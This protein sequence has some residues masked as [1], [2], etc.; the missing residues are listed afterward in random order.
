[1]ENNNYEHLSD[2][3]IIKELEIEIS[4]ARRAYLIREF[5]RDEL[6]M[7]YYGTI[8]DEQYRSS[9]TF[10]LKKIENKVKIIETLTNEIWITDSVIR[11]QSDKYKIIFLNV[12]ID[13]ECKMRI[14]QSLERNQ[15]ELKDNIYR[16]I[17]ER[18]KAFVISYLYDDKIK[19]A[20]LDEIDDDLNKS[21]IVMTIDDDELKKE[22]IEKIEDEGTKSLLIASLQNK[23][24]R[25]KYMNIEN[26]TYSKISVPEGMTVGIEIESEG[27]RALEAVCIKEIMEDW[28]VKPDSSLYNGIEVTSPIL[29]NSKENTQDLYSVCK[30]LKDLGQDISERCGGHI[31]IGANYLKSKQAYANLIELWVNNEELFYILSN[32]KGEMI[33]EDAIPYATPLSKKLK[34]GFKLKLFKE[35]ESLSTEEFINNI[36]IVQ[37]FQMKN[38]G[39]RTGINF[40]NI[41]DYYNPSRNTIEFRTPNGT[42][43]ADIWIENITLFG[44]LVSLSKKIS[45]LQ[46]LNKDKLS[47]ENKELLQK[48]EM[49]K[50]HDLSQSKKVDLILDL[51]V[52]KEMKNVFID[53]FNENSKFLDD[54]AELK[55]YIFDDKLEF[56]MKSVEAIA[57]RQKSRDVNNAENE[58]ISNYNS[59]IM[60]RQVEQR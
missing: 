27:E 24:E 46:E 43:D 14:L 8:T 20:Y 34:E 41:N 52:P 23:Q 45:E 15:E 59:Y 36:K 25:N 4:Q 57:S 56:T 44:G 47:D 30:V 9:I 6:I 51:C 19:K 12:V 38:G 28:D 60:P 58:L 39:R 7:K 32:K 22:Y 10:A 1:M 42:I 16:I 49:L 54:N 35:F 21:I 11:L 13:S 53:R 29:N 33:R 17:N 50:D 40:R 3:E 31:H 26:S 48:F 37:D 2:D 55:Q 18:D 5:S